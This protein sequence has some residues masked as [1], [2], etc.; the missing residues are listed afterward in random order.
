MIYT[1]FTNYYINIEK[2]KTKKYTNGLYI[3]FQ[4]TEEKQVAIGLDGKILGLNARRLAGI[5][6]LI[7]FFS[8]LLIAT[9][10]PAS[11]AGVPTKLIT[12]TDKKV[13]KEWYTDMG[14]TG[15]NQMI[16]KEQESDDLV[17]FV[18]AIVLDDEGKILYG[19]ESGL[20]GTIDDVQRLDHFHTGD[21]TTHHK[22][23]DNDPNFLT[24]NTELN[25]VDDGSVQGDVAGDGVY[26]AYQNIDDPDGSVLLDDHLLVNVTVDY[27][28]LSEVYQVLITNQNCHNGESESHGTHTSAL[29][30]DGAM[31]PCTYC[32]IGYEHMYEDQSGL[33][34]TLDVHFGKMNL[35]TV[36]YSKADI[37]FIWNKSTTDVSTY[38]QT[39]T[40]W[41]GQFPGSTYCYSCHYST[42]GDGVG[43]LYD[44]G[45]GDRGDLTDK[46]SCNVASKTLGAGSVTC[47]AVTNIT[48]STIPP[49][50]PAAAAG[51]TTS[52]YN[53][54]ISRGH[55][56]DD[57]GVE[58]V[59]CAGCHDTSHTLTM[60]NLNPTNY[61]DISEQCGSCHATFDK[62]N[63]TV[64]CI[65]CHDNDQHDIM[66]L[67]GDITY[68]WNDTNAVACSD[69]HENASFAPALG[70]DAPIVPPT[71]HSDDTTSGQKWGDYWTSE[72]M[73]A[74]AGGSQLIYSNLRNVMSENAA[75]GSGNAYTDAQV[76]DGTYESFTE[77][78]A[79]TIDE[80]AYVGSNGITFGT[81]TNL[82]N[83]QN[84]SDSEAF[85]TFASSS[86]SATNQTFFGHLVSTTG[87]NGEYAETIDGLTATTNKKY[88]TIGNF[89]GL[90]NVYNISNVYAS[91]LV[92]TGD[93]TETFTLSQNKG[94]IELVQTSVPSS[95]TEYDVDITADISAPSDLQTIEVTATE[96]A[97][98]GDSG[99]NVDALWLKVSY[100][101]TNAVNIA[102]S[103][104]GVKAD[105]YYFEMN[106]YT[107]GDTFDVLV[108]NGTKWVD[109]GD[110]TQTGTFAIFNISL[111]VDEHNEGSPQIK[112]IDKTADATADYLYVD[113]MAVHS[114]TG[115]DTAAS[116]HYELDITHNVPNVPTFKNTN[117]YLTIKGYMDN[118]DNVDL[119]V[120]D[121]DS[122]SYRL[123][124]MSKFKTTNQWYNIS[125]QPS[126]V[127]ST[128]DVK[129]RYVDSNQSRDDDIS[130]TAYL[131]YSGVRADTYQ[132][133]PCQSCHALNKHS[134][135]AKGHVADIKGSNVDNT[136]DDTTSRWCANCH[137]STAPE[138]NGTALSPNPPTIVIDNTGGVPG[139]Y[140][141]SDS[142][143]GGYNDSVCN[144]CHGN[145]TTSSKF[146]IHDLKV[147]ASGGP[148]CISCHDVGDGTSDVDFANMLTGAGAAHANLNSIATVSSY[149]AENK[150]CWGCH[151]TL[152]GGD[153]DEAD[154]PTDGHN[155]SVYMN[156]RTC[157]DC[158]T[159]AD[160]NTNFTAP[161]VTEHIQDATDVNTTDYCSLC[162]NNS[163]TGFTES[164]G[165]G[166]NSAIN[167]TSS[168]YLK[169]ANANLM[170]VGA[171][172]ED[173]VYCHFT[174]SADA[175]W[176][177]PVDPRPGLHDG[178]VNADCYGCHVDSQTAPSTFH[179][180]E[181]NAGVGSG[182]DCMSCHDT[183]VSGTDKGHID[184]DVYN[185]SIHGG[186]STNDSIT[187]PNEACWACHGDGTSEGHNATL[188]KNPFICEDCHVSGGSRYTWATNLSTTAAPVV[189]E[190]YTGG[191]DIK[192]SSDANTTYS[193]LACHETTGEMILS[194][195]DVDANLTAWSGGDG[196]GSEIGNST[197]PYH[198]GKKRTDLTP[199]TDAYCAYCH[200]NASAASLWSWTDSAHN[201]SIK[202]HTTDGSANV[203]GV[204]CYD[205]NC[206]GTGSLKIHDAGLIMPTP[207]V[208]TGGKDDSCKPCHE[209]AGSG[210]S[211]KVGA[212]E[213]TAIGESDCSACHEASF[214]GNVVVSV[215]TDT[216]TRTANTTGD[217]DLGT[218]VGCHNGSTY[219]VAADKTILTHY[220]GAPSGKGDTSVSSRECE[221]CHNITQS[222]GLHEAG[223]VVKPAENCDSCHDSRSSPYN[224][225]VKMLSGYAHDDPELA[226]MVDADGCEYCHNNTNQPE[227]FHFTP[228]ANGSVSA[229]GWGGW[230]NGTQANCI[231]C[232]Y[233]NNDTAPF[234]AQSVS[235][236]HRAQI[237]GAFWD[238][239]NCYSC[240]TSAA[241]QS[242]D[243]KAMHSV[244]AAPADANCTKC[245]DIGGESSA[246]VDVSAMNTSQSMHNN[247]NSLAADGG[248]IEPYATESK[249]CWACHGNGTAPTTHPTNYRNPLACEDCH[250]T[251]G[252]N[253]SDYAPVAVTEH[254]PLEF[255]TSA[256]VGTTSYC[257]DCH[258]NSV[259]TG[260]D[261]STIRGINE[262]TAHYGLN[263]TGSK[264][265][266]AGNDSLDC[267]YCHMEPANNGTWGNAM[268]VTPTHKGFDNGSQST[269]CYS[270]HNESDVTPLV[271][272]HSEDVGPGQSG[273]PDCISCHD[274]T[275]NPKGVDVSAMNQSSYTHYGLNPSA[276]DT[277]VSPINKACWACHGNG[278]RPANGEHQS[279][280]KDPYDC[281]YCHVNGSAPYGSWQIDE[282]YS[283][284][285]EIQTN[286]ALGVNDSCYSCHNTAEMKVSYNPTYANVSSD[287]VAH[288]SV[289]KDLGPDTD[290]AY[291]NY[292]HNN[293]STPFPFVDTHNKAITEHTGNAS[294]DVTNLTSLNCSDCHSTGRI[295]N[296][297]LSTPTAAVWTTAASDYCAPCH[298]T[299]DAGSSLNVANE[300]HNTSAGIADCGFC[301]DSD[302]FGTGGAYINIHSDNLTAGAS[303][304]YDTCTEC[305][306][307]AG[308][309]FVANAVN[310]HYNGAAA[311]KANTAYECEECHNI[312]I[313]ASMHS[314]GMDVPAEGCNE[315]HNDTG[316]T[317]FD[318]SI[319]IQNLN[320]DNSTYGSAVTCDT[321]HNTSSEP[322]NFHFSD[323]PNGTV[324]DTSWKSPDVLVNCID[325]HVT[326]SEALPY[327]AEP[328]SYHKGTYGSTV[329]E[330]YDCHTTVS[331]ATDA[332]ATAAMHNVTV[333][334]VWD[335]CID[336]HASAKNG[337]PVVDTTQVDAGIHQNV[338]GGGNDA[339]IACHGP[340]TDHFSA[341]KDCDSCHINGSDIY[342]SPQVAEHSPSGD[343]ISA[344]PV[345]GVNES[346]IT[347]HNK[348]E[349]LVS[350]TDVSPGTDYAVVSHYGQERTDMV[351]GNDAYCDYCH[352]NASTVFA[353]DKANNK[354]IME[355]TVNTSADINNNSL[356]CASCHG[357][358]SIH[359]STLSTPT[360]TEWTS[361][362]ADNCAPCHKPGDSN[363][364]KYANDQAHDPMNGLSGNITG[365]GFCHNS[366]TQ[367]PVSFKIH[368]PEMQET[369]PGSDTC[370]SCH[371]GTTTYVG[372]TDQILSH[373]PNGS[374]YRGNTSEDGYEC[375][376]CHGVSVGASMHSSGLDK[377]VGYDC[378]NCH[379]LG[380]A[381]LFNATQKVVDMNDFN[382]TYINETPSCNTSQCH[383]ASGNS[384]FHMD[385]YASADI[386]DPGAGWS[387]RDSVGFSGPLVDCIDCHEQHNDTAPFNTPGVEAN[388]T[389]EDKQDHLGS[390][391][392]MDNCYV[393]HTNRTDSTDRYMVHNV[394]IE[395]LAG[396]PN[397]TECHNKVSP[398]P[399]TD[400]DK[401]IDEA[402]LTGTAHEMLNRANGSVAL[403]ATCW[404]CHGDGTSPEKHPTNYKTPYVCEDCHLSTGSITDS[405]ANSTDISKHYQG[406]ASNWINGNGKGKMNNNC[407]SCHND[408]D[409]VTYSD[410]ARKDG[411]N[412]VHYGKNESIAIS[413]I[414][415]DI[416]CHDNS[417]LAIRYG[418]A[419][420]NNKMTDYSGINGT[421]YYCHN[422]TR[423]GI[424]ATSRG[425]SWEEPNMHSQSIDIYPRCYD[426]LGYDGGCHVKPARTND[427][428]RRRR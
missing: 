365:C 343:E 75:L 361:G 345:M 281:D 424:D 409:F 219:Y 215:H 184:Y 80:Y 423:N 369:V 156:P 211:M 174:N 331:T 129:I 167:A 291:C 387:D 286:T 44:Y 101:P 160:S 208:W 146:Y 267:I 135:D 123:Y 152:A 380:S 256:N 305:H 252:A 207:T 200:T 341:A 209:T 117:Y 100:S 85:A 340:S 244:E 383:N 154:Q 28:S 329:D 50:D 270:C 231:D 71:K 260:I 271:T 162:H 72:D 407:T 389:G 406:D 417:D 52:N 304:T 250:T 359:N 334:S 89:E 412:A 8:A 176:G 63:D 337:A 98:G 339:C 392:T 5:S 67:Q 295:H 196:Y 183:S 317:S 144:S 314:T 55:A 133:L 42:G 289:K 371:N 199:G 109:K 426:G 220:P 391:Y 425:A 19:R 302:V 82:A 247:L 66:Y 311:G 266:T 293:A 246:L 161:Q 257:T 259:A 230:T 99:G 239:D 278:T 420:V 96:T 65:V 34:D 43:E 53:V 138:Y 375:E 395:P 275:S 310:T 349:M 332:G 40:G 262:T 110:L 186:I 422:E 319:L 39:T 222:Y 326:N 321:C 147:G 287:T 141:H 268:L 21:D 241:T 171:H 73:V 185:T 192:A 189:A 398:D 29:D 47:H 201:T 400:E 315:C 358:A 370:T 136:T 335:N 401:R 284:S 48:G 367:S 421:C 4:K 225:T 296:S 234:N 166:I 279:N 128:G 404:A 108:Y 9:A 90:N 265:M 122:S 223:M 308:T 130:D 232:H 360:V 127:N 31:D 394:T 137:V 243:S 153:A 288:Y 416:A 298:L 363:A 103:I 57:S 121:Y 261:G 216:L 35:P 263:D 41:E 172:S 12:F 303:A 336:C 344:Y 32:H 105:V 193:C 264:L 113:Y 178:K 269:V 240:H 97:A 10:M 299:S 203:T 145:I 150:K 251:E 74:A 107:S 415:C 179:D 316:S 143:A 30:G 333:T 388:L 170:T 376:D 139:W 106:Y 368:D 253:Y 307:D 350:Y 210:S 353:F 182:P 157:P 224:A 125:I 132:F 377:P 169:D 116:S 428:G 418:D 221:D 51:T 348:S 214:T 374:Q 142:I 300:I 226:G 69:C 11:A 218:C 134:A 86:G 283:G 61:S 313:G 164:D 124:G 357:S 254:M 386:G 36:T 24:S 198:Y 206:H 385:Q 94:N 258:N 351:V 381:S 6:V 236:G 93:G 338:N 7:I 411:Y 235:S 112:I 78:W 330:C 148:D 366:T 16:Y 384:R 399:S 70:L 91:M 25:F 274:Q 272:F 83:A 54:T 131:D 323:Y 158:H 362:Q 87:T 413:Y 84:S 76:A 1:I 3:M 419:V 17:I 390:S 23:V 233:T 356:T 273:G 79:A 159:N 227:V 327:N 354:A 77:G 2:L 301:H 195:N 173:C 373:L 285:G 414:S 119:E 229:P 277:G 347:C 355:H 115:G 255:N 309:T 382:H 22:V 190:H 346:C 27:M 276:D 324:Q 194:N 104:T 155:N 402:N 187:D 405:Y 13:Y 328:E 352:S 213:P 403:S 111:D 58:N 26:T 114:Y 59:P 364:T 68:A 60:P 88:V 202:E 177:T 297:T 151:G 149:S 18:Y 92:S 37:S 408:S 410:P 197:S 191:T 33:Y 312:G 325:C 181:M 14:K 245:H 427:G 15:A 64:N 248:A 322:A 163:L 126:S 342:S 45:D 168:H 237:D 396:G 393:C 238:I 95:L 46:P 228:W 318:S 120:W 165:F 212:H 294:A 242:A 49:W 175:S 306:T 397:C 188:Y 372:A 140:N 102:P 292:C 62:H 280:Y 378:T 20:T 81:V 290:D 282:H 320:H 379:E 38:T 249:R 205:A 204:T 217:T 118:T 56:Y 180:A